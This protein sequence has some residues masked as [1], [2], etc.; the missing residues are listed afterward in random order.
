MDFQGMQLTFG[1]LGMTL[2]K[3]FSRVHFMWYPTQ[4]TWSVGFACWEP[5]AP[6]VSWGRCAEF[7]WREGVGGWGTYGVEGV[8]EVGKQ[9]VQRVR[10]SCSC[11]RCG[12][13]GREGERTRK[14]C[15]RQVK[16]TTHREEGTE[17]KDTRMTA[18]H[19]SN[20]ILWGPIVMQ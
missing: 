10:G 18:G 13:K 15:G 7:G 3:S 11:T 16:T 8:D 20:Q 14:W 1:R 5:T 19:H 17:S 2:R 9:I 4:S 6:A 12:K